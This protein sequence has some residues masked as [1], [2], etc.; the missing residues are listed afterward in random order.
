M[1]KIFVTSDHHFDHSNIIRYCKRPFNSAALMNQEMVH[2][3]NAVVG[4]EDIVYHLGDFT[5]SYI[6]TAM[7]WFGELKG[8]IYI[9]RNWQHHDRR[10]LRATGMD[11]FGN[12][13]HLRP[14][15]MSGLPI[16]IL[17]PTWNLERGRNELPIILSHFPIED[18][19]RKHHGSIHLH[20]HS[21]GR[22]KVIKGRMDVGVDSQDF[23]PQTIEDILAKIATR[24]GVQ[25]AA[26]KTRLPLRHPMAHH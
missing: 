19:D 3:W 25:S 26:D 2:R 7:H 13:G 16:Q 12:D 22:A 10:W 21:H 24:D 18:W 8:L 5:M 14:V 4:E 20:G 6:T 17:P 23:R 11:A 9:L 15:T 1:P